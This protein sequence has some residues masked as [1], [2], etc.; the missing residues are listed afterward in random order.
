[1]TAALAAELSHNVS[2]HVIVILKSQLAQ[3]RVGTSAAVLRSNLIA[4]YQA[5]LMA[6]LHAVHA[7]HI[8]S[9]RLVDAFAATVSAGE[10]SWLKEDPS[11]AE[12]IP[13]VTIKG[14][15]PETAAAV[16]EPVDDFGLDDLAHSECDP[17]RLRGQRPGTAR[18]R[19]PL[20]HEH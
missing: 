6:E 16:D 19:G 20:A 7:T 12:V 14:A 10:E 9:Y 13:D 15:A 11:I 2:Q 17:G 4:A 8:E 1:M 18:S 3:A 5:P